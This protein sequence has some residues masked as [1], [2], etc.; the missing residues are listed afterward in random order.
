LLLK[1]NCS[2][3]FKEGITA[4]IAS[5]MRGIQQI[6]WNKK[7]GSLITQRTVIS[8]CWFFIFNQIYVV[9]ESTYP[10]RPYQLTNRN[11]QVKYCLRRIINSVSHGK[12][13]KFVKYCRTLAKKSRWKDIRNMA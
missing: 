5:Y 3:L 1:K 10:L 4:P 11:R 6:S 8:P 9:E 12:N 2:L 7:A 13:D